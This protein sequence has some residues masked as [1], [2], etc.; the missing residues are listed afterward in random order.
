MESTGRRPTGRRSVSI[1]GWTHWTA[2][3]SRAPDIISVVSDSKPAEDKPVSTH[4]DMGEISSERFATLEQELKHSRETLQSTLEELESS[5]EEMQAT[6]EELVASNE[7]LQSTNEELHSVNEELHTVNAELQ[8]KIRELSELNQD[9]RLLFENIEVAIIFLDAEL[10]IRRFTPRAAALFGLMEHDQGRTL[11]SFQHPFKRPSLMA[12]IA[13]CRDLG[14]PCE[15]EVTDHHGSTHLVRISS[16]AGRYQAYGVVLS[17][18]DLTA[19][20]AARKR[21]ERLS[22]IVDSTGDAI[23]GLDQQQRITVWNPAAARLYGLED[24]QVL[25]TSFNQLL[26]ADA[27]AEFSASFEKAWS[28]SVVNLETVR[29]HQDGT[30]IAVATTLSAVRDPDGGVIGVSIIDRDIRERKR[31]EEALAERER[32][33]ADLYE[34]SPDMFAFVELRTGRIVEFNQ[35]LV[36]T[37]G[38]SAQELS[39]MPFA[40]L[41]GEDHRAALRPF[42]E[43]LRRTGEVR[44]FELVMVRKDGTSLDVSLSATG[45]RDEAGEVVRSRSV[46]RDITTRKQAAQALVEAS[47]M[48]ERF[49][50]LV[51]HE[52]RTPLGAMRSA[53]SLLSH[54]SADSAARQRAVEVLNRQA[55][56]MTR[57]LGDLLDVSL[58]THDRFELARVPLDLRD[59][60][61]SAIDAVV[62]TRAKAGVRVVAATAEEPLPLLGDPA[63]LEQVFTNLLN[64]AV[65]HSPP[66]SKIVVAIQRS[67]SR[68]I[69]T[70]TDEGEGIAPER[71][72]TIF[73]LFS[74]AREPGTGG[75]G[76]GLGLGI[77]RRIVVG[78]EGSIRAESDGVG[79]GARFIIELPLF[80]KSVR[81]GRSDRSARKSAD[82]PHRGSARCQRHG[83]RTAGDART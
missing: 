4:V 75:S 47:K 44:D 3:A 48:R 56:Q 5:S 33:L 74:R 17:I 29:L 50:A 9:M 67:G 42:E 68:A 78:H 19:L 61:R 64:N 69:V 28:G 49:L 8:S 76:L 57:L 53:T 83:Y 40:V 16:Y 21:F 12:D 13:A 41:F 38:Y 15:Y 77:A 59:P 37:L 10:R 70:V 25:D 30:P 31:R 51:S 7:E 46:A 22:S 63:R 1:C 54:P 6:N 34:H 66:G 58:I 11:T 65:R 45:E 18:T 60:V 79:R 32:R 82:R 20:A 72:R 36:Q 52:L 81:G 27:R 23:I 14:E 24:E 35:T 2:M 80:D 62:T 26:P 43:I 71:L 55:A 73:E 39:A